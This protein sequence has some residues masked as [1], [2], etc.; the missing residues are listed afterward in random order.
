MAAEVANQVLIGPMSPWGTALPFWIAIVLYLHFQRHVSTMGK[1]QWVTS[2]R[3]ILDNWSSSSSRLMDVRLKCIMYDVV[4]CHIIS[5]PQEIPLDDRMLVFTILPD[6][7]MNTEREKREL[8]KQQRYELLILQIE[9]RWKQIDVKPI[10]RALPFTTL[11]YGLKASLYLTP[12]V[13]GITIATDIIC[14][15]PG[16]TD[17]DFQETLDLV[18]CYRFPSLFINQ[19]YPR[20]GTPAAKMEQVAANVV[21][22]DKETVLYFQWQILWTKFSCKSTLNPTRVISL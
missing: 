1:C 12:R 17:E 2:F 5:F 16:E 14:G 22:M 19:F 9:W 3:L 13:P 8:T 6:W 21:S 10:S 20:P 4:L 7:I 18:K 11:L 15:F